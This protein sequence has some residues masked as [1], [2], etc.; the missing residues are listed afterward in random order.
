ME[1]WW[2][3][4]VNGGYGG[5]REIGEGF[6]GGGGVGFYGDGFRRRK[7]EGSGGCSDGREGGRRRCFAGER[8]E[9]KRRVRVTPL[10]SGVVAG[11]RFGR[12]QWW[13]GKRGPHRWCFAGEDEGMVVG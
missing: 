11:G 5:A 12:Q 4:G 13:K 10:F 9:K 7:G 6:S 3:A 1:V 8:K 2:V